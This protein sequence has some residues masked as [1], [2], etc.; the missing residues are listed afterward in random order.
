[1]MRGS[2]TAQQQTPRS[3]VLSLVI[4][5]RPEYVALCRLVARQLASSGYQVV[6]TNSALEALQLGRNSERDFDLLITDVIMPG[7]RGTELARELRAVRPDLQVLLISGYANGAD[8]TPTADPGF[9]LLEKP[10]TA[11]DLLRAVEELL[12][13]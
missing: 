4:P 1:M 12:E 3:S 13:E 10:F 9:R 8:D 11:D 5:G 2:M 6:E 7:L